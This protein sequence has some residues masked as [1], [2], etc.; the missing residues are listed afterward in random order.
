MA[1]GYWTTYSTNAFTT[2]RQRALSPPSKRD[3][4]LERES[5]AEKERLLKSSSSGSVHNQDGSVDSSGNSFGRGQAPPPPHGHHAKPV[6]NHVA[7]EKMAYERHLLL[8]DPDWSNRTI[9]DRNTLPRK[10]P[11]D[12]ERGSIS[13]PEEVYYSSQKS[14]MTPVESGNSRK[15]SDDVFC[16]ACAHQS[17]QNSSNRESRVSFGSIA[18]SSRG[19][20]GSSG[21]A[22]GGGRP[23]SSRMRSR[24]QEDDESSGRGGV[25]SS[26]VPTPPPPPF[27]SHS[28]I[29]HASL[30]ETINQ[31]MSILS[32]IRNS[33]PPPKY[34]LHPSTSY[35]H[36]PLPQRPQTAPRHTGGRGSSHNQPVQRSHSSKSSA[37]SRKHSSISL[38]EQSLGSGGSGPLSAT[39]TPPASAS[40]SGEAANHSSGAQQV[41]GN[42]PALPPRP[43]SS[44][45]RSSRSSSRTTPRGSSSHAS[46][47]SIKSASGQT[48]SPVTTEP[49]AC[50][51]Q[52]PED[53]SYNK[54]GD[55]VDDVIERGGSVIGIRR[56]SFSNKARHQ[57]G[58][59]T[60]SDAG[61]T[62]EDEREPQ[63][64]GTVRRRRRRSYS[65]SSQ[66]NLTQNSRRLSSGRVDVHQEQ[67]NPERNKRQFRFSNECIEYDYQPRPYSR[68]QENI[69]QDE[70]QP[71]CCSGQR[72]DSCSNSRSSSRMHDGAPAMPH[73]HYYYHRGVKMTK[74]QENLIEYSH[75]QYHWANNSHVHGHHHHRHY[76]LDPREQAYLRQRQQQHRSA[77]QEKLEQRHHNSQLRNGHT[78]PSSFTPNTM[79]RP[80]RP[81]SVTLHASPYPTHAPPTSKYPPLPPPPAT[82]RAHRL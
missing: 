26:S 18:S 36:P 13:P 31:K 72:D 53:G 8:G 50:S 63:E 66:E 21:G 3:H 24:S 80:G 82:Q 56:A 15:S 4:S 35:H 68:S 38:K 17:Q 65:K 22:G 5:R 45:P 23:M 73:H 12:Y 9:A 74:S 61:D 25:L 48:K 57:T 69:S 51:M 47:E 6:A 78:R 19:S 81:S 54:M 39:G 2:R 52:P 60:T 30:M 79:R 16:P 49:S 7:P 41:S 55:N 28:D 43:S 27:L 37:G 75:H 46:H 64:T 10:K 42:K 11:Y 76:T 71:S 20:R 33:L 58:N 70:D 77:S 14:P 67:P 29:V 40:S 1:W 32:S 62:D 44:H 59:Q 34:P